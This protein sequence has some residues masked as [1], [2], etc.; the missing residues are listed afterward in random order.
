MPKR[1][2][3]LRDQRAVGEVELADDEGATCV[4]PLVEE[5]QRLQRLVVASRSGSR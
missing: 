5:A 1:S 2:G 4:A 3:V